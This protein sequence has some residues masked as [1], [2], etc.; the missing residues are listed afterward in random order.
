MSKYGVWMLESLV[1]KYCDIGGSSRGM[2][3]FLD[4]ALPALRQQNPQLGVQQVLQRFR[5][6]KL[7]AVYRNGRTK[8]VCVKNLAPAEIMEHIGWLRNSHGRGQ[9]YQVVRSRHLSRSPSIQGT[10]S[11]DT[12]ASQLERVNEARRARE[13]AQTQY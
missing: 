13:A 3:L 7:V 10:W 12:F 8:P 2:R 1:I 11:V 4:E 9:E 5:H 6:P